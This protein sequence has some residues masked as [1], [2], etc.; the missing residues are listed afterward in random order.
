[1]FSIKQN[2]P[3]VY[4]RNSRDFQLMCN[5]FNILQMAT[6]FDIDSINNLTNTKLCNDSTLKLLQTKLGFFTNYNLIGE[7]LRT[8][9]LTFPYLIRKKGTLTGIKQCIQLFFKIVDKTRA[10]TITTIN[11]T[12]ETNELDY[13]TTVPVYVVNI[14]LLGK[15]FD[16]ALLTEM[17][18]YILPAGYGLKYYFQQDTTYTTP[19][20]QTDTLNIVFISTDSKSYPT[21]SIHQDNINIMKINEINRKVKS[22]SET[23]YYTSNI[24]T[25]PIYVKTDEEVTQ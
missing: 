16:V 25:T 13:E 7:D 22:T 14:S 17:L 15:T 18:R 2:M 21:T 1:M 20:F 24:N 4:V 9:L 10:V 19:I 8:L 6:K 23:T 12:T 11:N 5:T 3:D